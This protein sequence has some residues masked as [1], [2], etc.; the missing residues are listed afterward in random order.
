MC[1]GIPM[2][3]TAV[4]TGFAQVIGRCET[5]RIKT[6]LLPDLTAGQWVLVFLDDA[7]ELLTA[8]RAAISTAITAAVAAEISTGATATKI[9]IAK[10]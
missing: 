3:V 7:R 6:S 5:R 2:Q 10:T 8:Q 9:A 4:T 1:I